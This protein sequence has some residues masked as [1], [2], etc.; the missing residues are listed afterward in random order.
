MKKHYFFDMDG[1]LTPSRDKM[2]RDMRNAMEKLS[3]ASVREIGDDRNDIVIVSGARQE[4]IQTQVGNGP[5][6]V[7]A[8]NGNDAMSGLGGSVIWQHRL[9]WDLKYWIF[10]W[11]HESLYYTCEMREWQLWP[12]TNLEDLVEDRGCQV[13]FSIIGHNAPLEEKLAFDPKGE[14]RKELLRDRPWTETRVEVAIG[15]T[16]CLDFFL[17]GHNKGGNI[18]RF[19]EK[20]GWRREDCMYVGDQLYPGGNDHSVCGVIPTLEVRNPQETLEAIKAMI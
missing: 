5:W 10:R 13:S 3:W 19:I 20:M 9:P 4:Q 11:I 7:L 1:T 2:S 17:A 14:K 16:T 12:I 6:M 18:A 8:Q 15:G